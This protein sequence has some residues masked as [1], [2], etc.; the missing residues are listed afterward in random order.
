MLCVLCVS[1]CG[2]RRSRVEFCGLCTPCGLC[3]VWSCVASSSVSSSFLSSLSSGRCFNSGIM[4]SA[5]FGDHEKGW[6]NTNNNTAA[7]CA[8]DSVARKGQQ[9]VAIDSVTP[10]RKNAHH[11]DK[12]QYNIYFFILSKKSTDTNIK[13]LHLRI[14]IH[15]HIHIHTHAHTHAHTHESVLTLH[16]LIVL[17][18]P[19]SRCVR[20]CCVS[21]VLFLICLSLLRV[22]VLLLFLLSMS[23]CP[24]GITI[25][26]SFHVFFL[27]WLR[28]GLT[29]VSGVSVLS[30]LAL[31]SHL[32]C[33]GHDPRTF[34]CPLTI[35]PSIWIFFL[36][37]HVRSVHLYTCSNTF[38]CAHM[39]TNRRQYVRSQTLVH[40]ERNTHT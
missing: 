1:V 7:V 17:V 24:F 12:I 36:Y 34:S 20:C 39:F 8:A 28:S 19:F 25:F 6:H 11:H 33:L 10:G 26:H 31:S 30:F 40:A 16:L 14:H 23:F 29:L 9:L 21:F 27:T 4:W 37:L 32:L 3:C 38:S 15:H 35:F 22:R 5:G 18:V 2:L 13:H